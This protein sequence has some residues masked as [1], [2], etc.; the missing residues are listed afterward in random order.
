MFLTLHEATIDDMPFR[1]ALLSDPATMA[2]N[3]PWAPPDG[4]LPFPE[5]EFAPWLS[6]WAGHAPE[7]WCGYVVD[8]GGTNV[9]EVCWHSHGR[10]MG[11]VI[12]S[13][14]RGKHYGRE[15]LRL[16]IEEAFRHEEISALTNT[17]E[18]DR[19][20]ALTLHLHAGFVPIAQ[21]DGLLTLRLTRERWAVSRTGA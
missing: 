20:P 8:E 10:E 1:Q 21:R 5:S 13:A 9:G 15:A 2:Y 11:I 12:H 16:L 3:A 7:R 18:P 17:F 4:T 14:F 19:E 6:R